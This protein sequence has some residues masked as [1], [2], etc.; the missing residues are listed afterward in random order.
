M[1]LSWPISNGPVPSCA[2][3]WIGGAMEILQHG[4][5]VR[6]NPLFVIGQ[7]VPRLSRDLVAGSAWMMAAHVGIATLS[8]VAAAASLR[9]L[10]RRAGSS[11]SRFRLVSFVQKQAQPIALVCVP[12]GL[13][14]LWKECHFLR[15]MVL[16]SPE[17]SC[18][19]I[20]RRGQALRKSSKTPG[21]LGI[22]EAGIH[23]HFSKLRRVSSDGYCPE[24]DPKT[25]SP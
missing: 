24:K 14:V 7:I 3:T 22:M 18:D 2:V 19:F 8:I 23:P 20:D 10:A 9:P 12:H 25:Q 6:T 4:V 15:I 13:P 1:V 17:P 5:G 16:T 11:P 21:D